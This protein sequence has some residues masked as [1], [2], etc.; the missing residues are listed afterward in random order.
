MWIKVKDKFKESYA[1]ELY[2]G[3]KYNTKSVLKI[4]KFKKYYRYYLICG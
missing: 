4:K 3:I 1:S 2:L